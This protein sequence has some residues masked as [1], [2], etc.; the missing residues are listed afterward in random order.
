MP[1]RIGQFVP[2]RK[3]VDSLRAGQ[4][5]YIIGNIKSL[6]EVHIGDTVTTDSPR[7]PPAL[8][9]YAQPK[10]MVYCGLYPSDGQRLQR[11]A[12]RAREA[13]H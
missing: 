7:L 2:N 3:A 5:G 6:K 9:G 8:P 1:S 12:R 13:E 10:R 4:V 11:T